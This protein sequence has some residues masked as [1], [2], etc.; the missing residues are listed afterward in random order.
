MRLFIAINFEED[1]KERIQDII[2]ELKKSSLQGTYVNKEHIH[3]TLEFLGEVPEDKAN[4]IKNVID[5]V[6][7]IPF[8]LQL[9]GIGFFKRREG[10]IYWIGI[11]ENEELLKIRSQLHDRLIRE[12]FQLENR[13]YK[14]HLT[15]GRKILMD[16]AF[17]QEILLETIDQLKINIDKIELMK[18]EHINGKLTH[19]VIYT[20]Y[21]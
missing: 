11:E 4:I 9:E 20:R 16:E 12:G 8:I 3:L 5:Q 17:N 21:I 1:I 14:P 10:D 19:S 2:K 15:I 6:S 7:T 13:E 18:S